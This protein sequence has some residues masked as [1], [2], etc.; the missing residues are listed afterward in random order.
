LINQ[1]A[2]TNKQINKRELLLRSKMWSDIFCEARKVITA[3]SW[4][5]GKVIVSNICRRYSRISADDVGG[6]IKH[7]LSMFQIQNGRKETTWW[8][9][10]IFVFVLLTSS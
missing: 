10:G 4:N 6:A 9:E 1:Q 3:D 7:S 5:M 2:A 8:N